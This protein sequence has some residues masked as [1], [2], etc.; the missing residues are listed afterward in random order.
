[1]NLFVPYASIHCIMV[2]KGAVIMLFM[3][4]E[5]Q[6]WHHKDKLNHSKSEMQNI[7]SPPTE[8]L[9]TFLQLQN[10]LNIRINS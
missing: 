9:F 7:L 3:E 4:H 10:I 8:G 6:R 1:M 5:V 2:V